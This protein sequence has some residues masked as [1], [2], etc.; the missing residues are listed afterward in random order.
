MARIGR[1]KDDVEVSAGV[2]VVPETGVEPNDDRA[3][4]GDPE[5]IAERMRAYGAAGAD[6]VIV[7]LGRGPFVELDASYPEKMARVLRHL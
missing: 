5:H 1:P 6:V 3:I 7:S 4:S 2:L